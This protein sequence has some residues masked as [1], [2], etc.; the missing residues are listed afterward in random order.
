[1]GAVQKIYKQYS[2]TSVVAKATL[3]FI[4]C[5][6]VQKGISFFTTPIFTRL[7]TTEQYGQFSI[8]LSWLHILTI[9][10]TLRLNSAVFNKGMSKYKEDR[11]TYTASMQTTTF[12]ITSVV[13]LLYLVFRRQVNRL[14]ELPTFIMV[15]IFAELFVTPAIE[16]WTVR[17]RYEY[18]YKP[19]VFRTMVMALLNA[20]FGVIAVYF[21]VEKGYARILSC[22]AVT[23]CFGIVLFIYNLRKGKTIFNKEYVRFAITFN[24]PLLLHYFSQYV[25]DQFDRIMV[26]KLVSMAAA[27][28]YSV[29]YNVGLLL[30]IITT[31]INNAMTPWQ[32]GCLERGERKKMDDTMF[33]V[34]ILVA[35]CSF[36]LSS[37]APEIMKIL[38]NERYYEGVYVIPPVSM[39]LFF[40]FMYT[41]F[42]N[43][44]FFYDKNKFSMYISCAGA[45]LNV[46]LNY[47][48]IRIFGYIAAA[49]T[50]LICYILFAW[51]HY[52]YMTASIRAST[53]IKSVFKTRRLVLLSAGVVGFG[54]LIIFFYDHMILR[55]GVI[56]AICLTAYIN[57][58]R[59]KQ[60]IA[61][62]R[63]R[64]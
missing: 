18:S 42:A 55:Y 45:L 62:I 57:R 26:Q 31:S 29:A 33:L 13:F 30:R 14:T 16:F 39:G 4:I 49:Y 34:F 46:I 6:V 53:G 12:I 51:G 60:T 56:G 47:I 3:W 40:S 54:I 5:S 17:K 28:I 43:V 10:T 15:A 24:L 7:M 44:E 27:G 58:K 8:Y 2:N 64:K 1:M 20:G 37:F 35:G 61:L 9:L 41:T 25:L 48:G 32:Y 38:A 23:F 50:T 21:S 59:I 22:V 11:D 36:V 19:V 52:I 63:N